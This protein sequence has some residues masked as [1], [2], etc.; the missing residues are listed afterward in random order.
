MSLPG[1]S[2]I[3]TNLDKAINA[4]QAAKT[5]CQDGTGAADATKALNLIADAATPTRRAEVIITQAQD[6]LDAD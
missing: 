6:S 4:L 3:Q 2:G 5:A 1:L